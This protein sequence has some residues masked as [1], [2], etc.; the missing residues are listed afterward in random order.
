M[1]SLVLVSVVAC[2]GEEVPEIAPDAPA[3]E[4]AD[5]LTERVVSDAA[6]R[7]QLEFEEELQE[8]AEPPQS[9]IDAWDSMYER[10]VENA[11]FDPGGVQVLR[12]DDGT[13]WWVKTGRDVPVDIHGPCFEL[14]GGDSDGRSS[15]G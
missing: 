15:W 3:D 6:R 13:P 14:I 5:A 4:F 10:C 9:I 8:Q 11:G 2:A 1:A 12:T 7:A